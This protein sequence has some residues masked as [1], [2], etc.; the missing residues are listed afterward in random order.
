MAT[1][2]LATLAATVD[3][4]G[5][6]APTYAEILESLQ[7]SF[8]GIYGSDAYIAPDSQDGQLLAVVAKA[9]SDCNNA[10]IDTYNNYSPATSR[11][12]GLSTSVK[13]NGI[14]RRS[15]SSSTSDG[16]VVGVSGTVINGGIV[17]DANGAHQW[18]LPAVVTIPAEGE[19]VVTVTCADLGSIEA[20]VATLTRI[21]TPTLGWQTFS[22]TTE[23]QRGAPVETDASLRRRQASAAGLPG[24]SALSTVYAGL[25]QLV[26]VTEVSIHENYTDS[27]DAAGVPEHSI[28]AVIV[29]GDVDEIAA[30]IALKKTPGCNTF[31]TTSIMTLDPEGFPITIDFSRPAAVGVDVVINLTPKA[32]YST[33][34]TAAQVAAVTAYG[35]GLGIG[36]TLVFNRLWVPANLAG[37]PDSA[38]FELVSMTANG[39]TVDIDVAYDENIVIDSV[40][41]NPV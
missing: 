17:S 36:D 25:G 34:V 15:S 7:A 33:D 40:V 6:S 30:S 9:I 26:G 39:A 23:A 41:V 14:R 3:A 28:A 19:I 24:V 11:G 13:M 10:A 38:T 31:G 12:G 2:P 21:V 8:Q 32:G 29:G 18:A 35:D 20:P 5:I 27:T 4:D 22:N 1:F 37:Q 16:L